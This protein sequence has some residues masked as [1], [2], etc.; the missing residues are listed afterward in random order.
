VIRYG[1]TA[2]SC[3]IIGRMVS[4][5]IFDYSVIL[6]MCKLYACFFCVGEDQSV[7]KI[8][9]IELD[10]NPPQKGEPVTVSV[11]TKLCKSGS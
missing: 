10:P 4:N 7:M 11:S 6:C 1:V 8:E 5:N 9:D 2:V 3:I